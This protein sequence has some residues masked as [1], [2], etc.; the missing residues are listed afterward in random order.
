[1]KNNTIQIEYISSRVIQAQG[2]IDGIT[3]VELIGTNG[4]TADAMTTAYWFGGTRVIDTNGD[5][6]W[7]EQDPCAFAAMMEEIAE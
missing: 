5:P 7:E 1:M 2:R 3:E 6:I 4:K